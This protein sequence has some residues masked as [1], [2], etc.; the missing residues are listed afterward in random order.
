MSGISAIIKEAPQ[1]SLAPSTI[2]S[3]SK[4][5]F[6]QEVG[7]A[8]IPNLPVPWSWTSPSPEM[9]DHPVC[10]ICCSSPNRLGHW[11]SSQKKSIYFSGIIAMDTLSL[12][13]C[14][15]TEECWAPRRETWPGM[16]PTWRKSDLR[17]NVWLCPGDAYDLLDPSLPKNILI[18]GMFEAIIP[19]CLI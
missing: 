18:L 2:W 16:K 3:D 14:L 6:I 19:F 10:G 12:T 9:W 5:T 4:R 1:C 7:P 17:N 8:Q 15:L 11:S 13:L